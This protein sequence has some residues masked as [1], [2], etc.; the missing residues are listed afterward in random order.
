MQHARIHPRRSVRWA[1]GI[2]FAVCASSLSGCIIVTD[3][4]DV[5]TLSLEWSI[6]G[7][8]RGA[9]C[10]LVGARRTEVV[11]FDRFDRWVAEFE[12]RCAAFGVGVDLDAGRYVAEITLVDR[13]DDAVSF[14][15]VEPFRVVADTELILGVDF[16]VDDLL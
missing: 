1:I 7:D 6:E 16:A 15:L 8:T 9:D 2:G 3:D 13:F 14:T 5:G 10:D 11:L 12:P 4:F